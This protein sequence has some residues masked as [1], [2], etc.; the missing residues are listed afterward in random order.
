MEEGDEEIEL[1]FELGNEVM[2]EH[3]D[4]RPSTPEEWKHWTEH[5]D[6]NQK[7]MF[8]AL[9]EGQLVGHAG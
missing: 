1:F 6:F 4:F 7:G 3:F 5:P 8:F 2:S 9:L